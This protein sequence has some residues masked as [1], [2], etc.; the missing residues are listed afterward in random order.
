MSTIDDI[1]W[2][3]ELD[4]QFSG[5]IT[6]FNK[7]PNSLLCCRRALHKH[8]YTQSE[9]WTQHALYG[10]FF[11]V[12]VSVTLGHQEQCLTFFW[13][14]C[15]VDFDPKEWAFVSLYLFHSVR[16]ARKSEP[17][18]TRCWFFDSIGHNQMRKWSYFSLRSRS[19]CVGVRAAFDGIFFTLL[20]FGVVCSILLLC[21]VSLTRYLLLF[22]VLAFPSHVRH[23]PQHWNVCIHIDGHNTAYSHT[24]WWAS[25]GLIVCVLVFFRFCLMFLRFYNITTVSRKKYT[26]LVHK[27]CTE[28][29]QVV[30]LGRLVL[31]L[32]AVASSLSVWHSNGPQ[33]RVGSLAELPIPESRLPNSPF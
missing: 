10:W 16:A 18:H 20:N 24:D 7:I 29:G 9:Q 32:V 14:V 3:N 17:V 31:W 26:D 33:M 11:S 2:K 13:R 1:R 28:S 27:T 6:K 12:F 8:S 23:S 4:Q 15:V 22:A 25:Q 5:R 30:S 19:I 21:T